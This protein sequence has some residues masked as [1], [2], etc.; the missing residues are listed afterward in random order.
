MAV[1]IRY[2]GTRGL[3]QWSELNYNDID[4]I[5]NGFVDEFKLA[6]NNLKANNAA[7]GSRAGSFA[8]FGAGSGTN[9][10][11]IYMAYLRGPAGNA[12]QPVVLHRQQLDEHELHE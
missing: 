4:I 7:G 8:Y 1:D 5:T 6:V 12:E 10:L 9:P 3:D 11:P 2:V